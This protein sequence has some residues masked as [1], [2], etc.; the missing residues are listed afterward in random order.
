[1]AGTFLE[2]SV[3][4]FTFRVKAGCRYSP[5]GVWLQQE[6]DR[7]RLG[8]TDYLQQTSGD[9]AFVEVSPPE[10]VLKAGDRLAS[11]ETVKTVVEVGSP[12][13]G[14]VVEVNERLEAN[15]ELVN[16]DPYGEGWI[17]LVQPTAWEA[18]SAA[19]MTDE[20]YLEVV[21]GVASEELS[22]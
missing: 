16:E 22:K 6:G 17:A 3:D 8:L 18:E 11:V 14:T 9:M 5:E 4:K 13:S 7:V 2:A 15:P 10:T 1:M 20:R 12:L 21:Y 19:L